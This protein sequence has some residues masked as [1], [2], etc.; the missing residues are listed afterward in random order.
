MQILN[1]SSE[2]L[3]KPLTTVIGIVE[4]KTTMPILSN[5]LIKKRGQRIDFMA[6]DLEIEITTRA[7][8]GVGDHDLDVTVS[9]RKLLELLRSLPQGGL[10]EMSLEEQM[11]HVVCGK[12][13]FKLQTMPGADF[14]T[15]EQP[16]HWRQ[17]EPSE[18]LPMTLALPQKTLKRLFN[19]VS[20]AMARQDIRY[21]LNGILLVFETDRV[22]AVATDGHRLAHLSEATTSQLQEQHELILPSKTVIEM[23]RLLDDSEKP[24]Y[25]SLN[26][27][28]QQS[29]IRFAFGDIVLVS[30][31]IEG[32]FPDYK[33]VIPTDCDHQ[34]VINKD[35]LQSNLQRTR[36][37]VADD[38]LHAI[39]L[40]FAE[41]E[42]TISANNQEQERARN[43]VA[44]D[45]TADP[46]EIGF[47]V[48]YLLDALSVIKAPEISL[49]L[50]ANPNSSVVVKLPDDE[51]FSYV[52]MPLRI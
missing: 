48:N 10:V 13:Q 2:L 22:R 45:Y 15:V 27:G 30:K 18:S 46:L 19:M 40:Q 1:A 42:L 26:Q 17:D 52:V 28:M 7:D 5:I 50:N 32:R 6:T 4:R 3:I 51:E 43:S 24:V 34:I 38:R 29:Q 31:L 47:N 25:I 36:I 49:N 39:K 20:F 44:I 12:S 33:Q 23:Q 8:V 21:Y 11:I 16:E 37:L 35:D 9:A 41:N 14:P